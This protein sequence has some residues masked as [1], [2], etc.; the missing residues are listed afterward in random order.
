MKAIGTVAIAFLILLAIS[1]QGLAGHLA[2]G[3][4]P[5]LN[6]GVGVDDPTWSYGVYPA[7]NATYYQAET[8]SEI[9]P[10][11]IQ[12]SGSYVGIV[13]TAWAPANLTDC[14]SNVHRG[15]IAVQAPAVFAD[16]SGKYQYNFQVWFDTIATSGA[17]TLLE[18]SSGTLTASA[19]D[20]VNYILTDNPNNQPLQLVLEIQDTTSGKSVSWSLPLTLY[21]PKWPCY[22]V[23]ALDEFKTYSYVS[24]F[25]QY[26]Y[27]VPSVAIEGTSSSLPFSSFTTG[28]WNMFLISCPPNNCVEN[29]LNL[30]S[31]SNGLAP[32]YVGGGLRLPSNYAMSGVTYHTPCGG[33]TGLSLGDVA[34]FKKAGVSYTQS[35]TTLV[36]SLNSINTRFCIPT[37]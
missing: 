14:F 1:P 3:N 26:F 11:A 6:F 9:L 15:F 34:G 16:S 24:Q 17:G 19:G 21:P 36:S 13:T 18:N 12:S 31:F 27:I 23:V 22:K 2:V 33:E 35:N 8:T 29:D 5:S 37:G 7:Y 4:A 28:Q 20:K 25:G 10:S 32:A 30:Y